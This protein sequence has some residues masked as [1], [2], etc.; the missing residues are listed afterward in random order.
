LIFHFLPGRE[1]IIPDISRTFHFG[2]SGLNVDP[3]FQELYF[4]SH[5]L[6]QQTG[7]TFDIE[8]IKKDAYEKEL[9]EII[10]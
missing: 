5:S 2:A 8:K 7:N 4:K 9:E 1:C 10:L 6:N 3:N